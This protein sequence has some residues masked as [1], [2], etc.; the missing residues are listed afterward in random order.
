MFF[1]D[2]SFA[3]RHHAGREAEV[4][5]RSGN[6]VEIGAGAVAPDH[7]SPMGINVRKAF[8]GS[9]SFRPENFVED[10]DVGLG[11]ASRVQ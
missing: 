4:V 1:E 5:A 11:S 10:Q 2:R 9:V 7:R 3:E 6:G 8:D